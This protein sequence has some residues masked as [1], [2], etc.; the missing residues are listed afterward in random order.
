MSTRPQEIFVCMKYDGYPSNIKYYTITVYK[1]GSINR[2]ALAYNSHSE[3]YFSFEFSTRYD[4]P[5]YM[6]SVENS[7]GR[8]TNYGFFNVQRMIDFAKLVLPP[9]AQLRYSCPSTFEYCNKLLQYCSDYPGV[10]E[11]VDFCRLCS[12]PIKDIQEHDITPCDQ[13]DTPPVDPLIDISPADEKISD[14]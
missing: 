9:H 5:L 10:I 11:Y 12:T 7:T 2:L 3:L 6:L 8:Y 1:D 13:D 14:D 4:H